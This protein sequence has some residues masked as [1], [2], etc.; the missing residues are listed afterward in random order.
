MTDLAD[1]H[2]RALRYL[3]GNGE[4]ACLNLGT[5]N[6]YSV[7]EVVDMVATCAGRPIPVRECPRRPGD[8][9]V[10]VANA[11]RARQVLAWKPSCSGLETIV[12]TAWHWHRQG[13]AQEAGETVAK[14]SLGG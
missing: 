5:G 3:R 11:S 13:N 4:S 10:L 1:A 9:P 6:G 2:V 14:A 7:R 8:P 12:A